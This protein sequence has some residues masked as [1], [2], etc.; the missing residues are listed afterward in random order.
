[1]IRI[2]LLPV[3]A[4][5]KRGQGQKQ[6][7][8]FL[9]LFIALFIA[10]FV[11]N[12]G[13]KAQLDQVIANRME[14]EK[15]IDKHKQYVKGLEV[16][17]EKQKALQAKLDV[18]R[19]LRQNKETPVTY[20]TELSRLIP[21]KVWLESMNNSGAT[22]VL[23]GFAADHQDIAM[24]M[25]ALEQSTTFTN[26]R[27]NNI[28]RTTVS[29]PGMAGTPVLT[30]KINA[31]LAGKTPPPAPA[32]AERRKAAPPAKKAGLDEGGDTGG[33]GKKGH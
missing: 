5:R 14:I 17:K 26:V 8:V 2:N 15:E 30:F 20:L 33:H 31:S 29:L 13:Q 25:N 7:A 16:F 3:K 9:L 23:D 12:Q 11:V 24:F 21:R 1:M 27:L 28:T 10:L 19:N 18:I 32:A 6:L 4:A 22:L